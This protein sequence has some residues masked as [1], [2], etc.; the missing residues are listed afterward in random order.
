MKMK[1]AGVL[2]VGVFIASLVV[3]QGA[4]AAH[5]QTAQL[6]AQQCNGQ[7]EATVRQGPDRS[8]VLL[9]GALRLQISPSGSLS[10]S[11]ASQ[12]GAAVNVSGQANG[13]AINLFFDLGGGKR[14]FGV[15]TAEHEVRLCRGAMGGPFVGP[16]PGDSGDW[17]FGISG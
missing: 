2:L 4:I 13:Q 1:T 12:K 11:L 6:G 17:G 8:Q 7:F 9:K 15:G 16:R 5:G 14:F 10:G 3:V